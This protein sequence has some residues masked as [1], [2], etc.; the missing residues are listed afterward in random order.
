MDSIKVTFTLKGVA[1]QSFRMACEQSSQKACDFAK[2]ASMQE[3][4]KWLKVS[5]G[6]PVQETS[7]F[8]SENPQVS[9]GGELEASPRVRTQ[10]DSINLSKDKCLEETC[11]KDFFKTFIGSINDLKFP[12]RISKVIKLKWDS[13]TESGLTAKEMADAYNDYVAECRKDDSK[14]CHPNSWINDNGWENQKSKEV[15]NAP[16]GHYDF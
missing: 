12:E 7:P 6:Y 10:V 13:I 9:C 14:F 3:V 11:V 16:V 4:R 1:A 8:I 15:T 2:S 5:S